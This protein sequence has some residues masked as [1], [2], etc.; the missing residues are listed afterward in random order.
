MIYV[1]GRRCCLSVDAEAEISRRDSLAAVSSPATG[2]GYLTRKDKAVRFVRCCQ[3]E[4]CSSSAFAE[5]FAV[6]SPNPSHT[7][8]YRRGN[9]SPNRGSSHL[10]SC[11]QETSPTKR[12]RQG[13]W[14]GPAAAEAPN[15]GSPRQPPFSSVFS[16]CCIKHLE[17]A[18]CPGE[19]SERSVRAET[20]CR[21]NQHS[22]L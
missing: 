22:R 5:S 8:A 11:N 10:L 7:D 9:S 4:A 3:V 19:S 13:W 2:K 18:S 14:R 1:G 16:G 15:P 21:R 12:V 6:R 17:M 20:K